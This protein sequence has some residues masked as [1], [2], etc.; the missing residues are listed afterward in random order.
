MGA[1]IKKP[2]SLGIADDK[3][4]RAAASTVSDH[5]TR[6]PD[7]EARVVTLISWYRKRC[8]SSDQG[9]RDEDHCGTHFGWV[10]SDVETLRP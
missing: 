4:R 3:I 9:N 2:V 5:R 7:Q 10:L 1:L 6:I 8:R